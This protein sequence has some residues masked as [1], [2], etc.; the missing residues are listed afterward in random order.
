MVGG[1]K[2]CVQVSQQLCE[3]HTCLWKSVVCQGISNCASPSSAVVRLQTPESEPG[4]LTGWLSPK[5][6]VHYC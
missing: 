4:R 6:E 2:V 3:E 5:S 1:E